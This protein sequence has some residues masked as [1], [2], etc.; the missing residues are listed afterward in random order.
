MLRT[1]LNI[2]KTFVKTIWEVLIVGIKPSHSVSSVLSENAGV[3]IYGQGTDVFR[4]IN[5]GEDLIL[6]TEE[7]DTGIVSVFEVEKNDIEIVLGLGTP[8][9]RTKAVLALKD[10]AEDVVDLSGTSK[11][12][13]Q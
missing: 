9:E 2:T 5:V 10:A 1:I 3:V 11:E 13:Y 7:D 4:F 6:V 12:N 8:I